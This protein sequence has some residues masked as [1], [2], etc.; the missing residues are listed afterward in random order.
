MPP[1]LIST[2]LSFSTKN[3]KFSK[4]FAQAV[5][6]AV[7]DTAGIDYHIEQKAVFLP[8]IPEAAEGAFQIVRMIATVTV[9]AERPV[10]VKSYGKMPEKTAHAPG[11]LFTPNQSSAA[12]YI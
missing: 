6:G 7:A 3:T 5:P 11:H 8:E 1:R 4:S 9:L 10:A 12:V 2:L